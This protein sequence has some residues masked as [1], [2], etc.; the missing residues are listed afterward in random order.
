MH[1]RKPER[2]REGPITS[3][4]FPTYNPGAVLE[5]T[6][7]DVERFLRQAPG[8]WEILFVCDGC[9][10]DSAARL[11]ALVRDEAERVRVLAYAPNRGKG[12]AVRHGLAAARGQWRLFTDVDLAYGLDDV[13]RV[14]VALHAGADVAIAS[15]L[16]PDSRLILPPHLQGYAYRRHLQSLI[17]SAL[18]RLLLPLTQ[19]DTQAGLKGLNARTADLLLPHF[20]CDGFGFDCELLT[21]CVRQ[22]LAIAEVPVCVRYD[23]AA[24]TTGWRAMSRMV[25]ELWRIRRAWR[26]R[27]PFP[28]SPLRPGQREAA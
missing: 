9:T 11:E 8:N 6:W 23:D 5:R 4:V 3:L 17:F 2:G 21:A 24:S 26:R 28:A 10:D 15:R 7:R 13:L 27:P 20:T 1:A 22:G 16:H 14:A 19:R 12:Y 25:G 18:V